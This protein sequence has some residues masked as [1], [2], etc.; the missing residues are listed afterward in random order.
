M[1]I[2]HTLYNVKGSIINIVI[3]K[4]ANDNERK[5]TPKRLITKSNPAPQVF[6][7]LQPQ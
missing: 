5:K 4:S 6:L 7:W 1:Y 2:G 3:H